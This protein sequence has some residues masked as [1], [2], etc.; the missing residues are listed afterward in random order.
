MLP[1]G[2]GHVLEGAQPS[3][4]RDDDARSTSPWGAEGLTCLWEG[5]RSPDLLKVLVFFFFPPGSGGG[6]HPERP[7]ILRAQTQLQSGREV[8]VFGKP[9]PENSHASVSRSE[10]HL[11]TS[12]SDRNSETIAQIN[13][14][15]Q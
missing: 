7:A 6:G 15:T 11:H 8:Y 10:K 5:Q 2:Q 14:P 12:S 13:H 4:Q 1:L 3:G 9:G